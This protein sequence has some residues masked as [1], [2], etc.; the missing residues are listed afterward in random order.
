MSSVSVRG[1]CG[2]KEGI[3]HL[4]NRNYRRPSQYD[5]VK[6]LQGGPV[7]IWGQQYVRASIDVGAAYYRFVHID[8]ICFGI[9]SHEDFG[10][11]SRSNERSLGATLGWSFQGKAAFQYLDVRSIFTGQFLQIRKLLF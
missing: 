2:K 5:S 9:L 11:L 8:R 3:S 6:I 10:R 7:G 1:L 4:S